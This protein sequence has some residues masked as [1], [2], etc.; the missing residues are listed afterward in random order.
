MLNLGCRLEEVG[1][2]NNDFR[3]NKTSVG[4]TQNSLEIVLNTCGFKTDKDLVAV[5]IP[6]GIKT[7]MRSM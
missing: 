7:T 2:Q 5:L 3:K 6:L 1:L 4:A